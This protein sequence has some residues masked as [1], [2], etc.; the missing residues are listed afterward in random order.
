MESRYDTLENGL[1]IHSFVAGRS[2]HPGLVLIHGYPANAFLWREC[3]SKLSKHFQIYA[4]DL[5]GHGLSDKPL[6]IEYDLDFFIKFLNEYYAVL[7]IEK[8]HLVVH[9][10]GGMI[11]L[12]FASIHPEKI[13]KFI[14]MDT[15]PYK[16]LPKGMRS[17]YSSVRSPLLSKILLL[18]P[19]FTNSFFRGK[20]LVFDKNKI[21]AETANLYYSHWTKDRNCKKAFSKILGASVESFTEPESHLKNIKAPTLILWGEND[22]AMG[23]DLARRLKSDISDSRLKLVPECGHFLPEEQPKIVSNHILNFLI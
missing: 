16:E 17:F 18:K 23:T 8:A 7:E 10:L 11:G 21:D 6:D 4:P 9:D 12:K 14:V 5:P 13:D 22:K 19:V 15:L 20:A 2:K 1:K 3:I